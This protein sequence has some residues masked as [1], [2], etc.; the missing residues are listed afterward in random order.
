MDEE[1]ERDPLTEQ[2]AIIAQLHEALGTFEQSLK[3]SPYVFRAKLRAYRTSLVQLQR[4]EK[5]EEQRL[6][7]SMEQSGYC[8]PVIPQQQ[9][10]REHGQTKRQSREPGGRQPRY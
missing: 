4:L 5:E 2:R 6:R 8:F 3:E 1:L 9:K 10:K 7:T